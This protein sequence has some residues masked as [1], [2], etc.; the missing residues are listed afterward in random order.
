MLE[1]V[2]DYIK[3]KPAFAP[4][5]KL[6]G[7]L[8]GLPGKARNF[9]ET[10]YERL[11]IGKFKNIH[12]HY[13]RCFIV[14]NGPSIKKQDLTLLRD[15]IVFVTNSFVL[16]EQYE[17]IAP[18]YYCVSDPRFFLGEVNPEWGE[19]M[20][21]KTRDTVKFLPL[22]ARKIVAR[23]GLLTGHSVYYLNY[24]P[25]HIWELGAMNLDPSKGVYSGDS[26]IIDFCLPLAFYMGFSE[27]YLLGCETD[28]ALDKTTDY[29]EG[30][31]YD[32]NK[33]TAPRQSREYHSNNWYYNV[34]TSYEVADRFF[35]ANGRR[36]YNATIGGKLEVFPRV[37]YEDIIS[38][39]A[40]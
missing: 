9:P 31:F 21:E 11:R 15:E 7:R 20:R 13:K 10:F 6:Y 18:T 1:S 12:R 33:V 3:S 23:S 16:H 28:Y 4:A 38:K 29:S 27:I 24:L 19:F 22:S 14:G 5:M 37:K 30:Y 25:R 8:Y 32:V 2:K 40:T 26:V 36:I 17:D 39:G 35:R 34:I